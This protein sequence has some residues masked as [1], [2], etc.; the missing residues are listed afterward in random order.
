MTPWPDDLLKKCD[1]PSADEKKIFVRQADVYAAYLMYTDHEIGRVVQAVQDLGKLD[2]TLIIFICG[3]N[4][5]SAEGMVNGT[6]SEVLAM[7]GVD[8]PAS[9]QLK[10]RLDAVHQCCRG[11]S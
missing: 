10:C 6:M 5:A 9:E 1:I 4:G 8:M 2:N 3:D 11:K 7:N